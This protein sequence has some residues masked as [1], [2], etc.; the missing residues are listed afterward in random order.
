VLPFFFASFFEGQ[1]LRVATLVDGHPSL[2]REGVCV[3]TIAQIAKVNRP[4]TGESI[5]IVVFRAFRH[6]SANYVEELMG[7]G[8]SVAFQ[9]G[10]RELGREVGAQ[11]YQPKLDDYLGAVV[12][13]VRDV[14]VGL[15]RPVRMDDK[16]LVVALDECIT[17]AGMDNIGKR[18]C[19]F[20]VG[21]VAG[22]VEAFVKKKVRASETKCNASGDA[23]CEVTVEL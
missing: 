18:I 23:T 17:C 22:V 19:F 3:S 1:R 7:R 12:A 20:E 5:P 21:L 11:L 13:W 2:L 14:K 9:N 16:Q 8:A 15:L 10:G 4:V 6:F